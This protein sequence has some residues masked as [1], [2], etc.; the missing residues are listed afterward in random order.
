MIYIK[1]D[2]M[3]NLAITRNGPVHRGDNLFENLIY[4]IP[5]NLNGLDP[6]D[7]DVCLSY[8]RPDG[9]ADIVTL[10]PKEEMYNESY[11]QYVIPVTMDMTKSPGEL[12]TWL[13]IV[14]K[15]FEPQE[16]IIAKSDECIIHVADSKDL[17]DLF[18]DDKVDALFQITDADLENLEVI[19]GGWIVDIYGGEKYAGSKARMILNG[20]L[21]YIVDGGNAE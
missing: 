7:T 19:D 17:R 9:L 21:D 2:T 14:E 12:R 3:M 8:I 18:D 4:L 11:Y 5:K 13:I 6:F 1:L 10:E 15:G 16:S 20:E